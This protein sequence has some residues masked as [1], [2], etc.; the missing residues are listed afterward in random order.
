MREVKTAAPEMVKSVQGIAASADGIA[1]DAKLEADEITRPKRWWQKILG[2]V[3]TVI[4][5]ISLFL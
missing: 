3:Y 5:C 1:A 4:R 2:P